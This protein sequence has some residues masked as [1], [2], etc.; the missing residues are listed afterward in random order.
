[1]Q[2]QSDFKSKHFV[3]RGN[4]FKGGNFYNTTAELESNIIMSR[5]IVDLAGCDVPWVIMANNKQEKIERARRYAI[6]FVLAFLSPMALLPALNRVA[7]KNF[8]KLTKSLWSNSHKAIHLSNKYLVSAE[9]TK[10][11][12]AELVKNKTTIGPIESLYY[13][14]TKKKPVEQT[15]NIEELLSNAGG[16]YEKLRQKLINTKN[17]VLFTDFLLSGVSLGV[18]G[19]VNNYLTKKKT[20]Q[21]GFSA[22]LKMADK[23]IIERR[24]DSYEKNKHKRYAAFAGL[25]LAISTIPPLLL[26]HGLSSTAKNGFTDFVKK[27]AALMDY[28]SG[29]YMSRLAFF[30]LLLINHGGL[31]LASRN[32]TEAKDTAIRMGSGD[33]IFFGG[34][35]LL[36]SVFANVSDRLFKTNLRKGGQSSFFSK[37]FPKTKPIKDINTLVNKGLME[38]K[39]KKTAN[40]LYWVNLAVLSF[41][42]GFVIPTLINKMIRKD[43]QKDVDKN[44]SSGPKSSPKFE[45]SAKD[46]K[47]FKAFT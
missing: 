26:K 38:S 11:G 6:V 32:K 45:I 28:K 27:H 24:A 37:I 9:K 17:G 20:G 35:I 23:N 40:I 33:A 42:M 2:V 21:S 10:E 29:I 1:M 39:N 4:S 8:A 44:N 7:M 25:A 41:S 13:K 5:A 43:V 14:I 31:L 19:F 36:A 16:D 30:T 46:K 3:T 34:D 47:A 15:L 18:L 22:E 12:L